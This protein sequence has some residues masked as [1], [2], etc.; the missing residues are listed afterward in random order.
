MRVLLYHDFGYMVGGAETYVFELIEDL[1]KKVDLYCVFHDKKTKIIDNKFYYRL[2]FSNF[3]EKFWAYHGFD[4]KFYNFF[5][6]ILKDVQPDIIHINNF[7]IHYFPILKAIKEYPIVYTVHDYGIVCPKS[8]AID[9]K[10]QICIKGPSFKCLLTG[11]ISPYKT[12]SFPFLKIK[13]YLI[14]KRINLLIA[15]SKKLKEI[16][17]KKGFKNVK[18]LNHFIDLNKWKKVKK[19]YNS[20]KKIILYVG[21]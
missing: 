15:P 12:I 8:W 18:V 10:G 3:I 5:K 6:K 17:E 1:R 21:G 19:S 7:Y 20:N 4:F 9:N 2:N 13:E 14:K 16:L 11:C